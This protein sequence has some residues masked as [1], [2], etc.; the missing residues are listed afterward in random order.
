MTEV[1]SLRH[2]YLFNTTVA[3]SNKRPGPS[4]FTLF[5]K[6]PTEL[7]QI[8]WHSSLERSRIIFLNIVNTDPSLVGNEPYDVVSEQETRLL[9][10]LLRVNRDARMAALIFYRVHLPCKAWVGCSRTEAMTLHINPEYDILYLVTSAGASLLPFIHFLKTLDP[11]QVGLLNLALRH[12]ELVALKREKPDEYESGLKKSLTDMLGKLKQVYLMQLNKTGR[13]LPIVQGRYD[14][15]TIQ[16]NRSYPLM[17]NNTSFQRFKRDPR[18]IGLDLKA[19]YLD[20]N[21][22]AMMGIWKE[23]MENWGVETSQTEIR[24]LVSSYEWYECGSGVAIQAVLDGEEDS[25]CVEAKAE[26]HTSSS[27]FWS[28]NEA[29]PTDEQVQEAAAVLPAIGFWLF[30]PEAV[31]SYR[32]HNWRGGW[33]LIDVS[34]YWPELCVFDV[35]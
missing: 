32:E 18:A 14:P 10:K 20:Y 31:P 30:P 6:L 28:K 21:T 7:R 25:V 17:V 4:E 2:D 5:P 19:V 3:A 1:S 15:N 29:K 34:R 26:W 13:A 35:D 16:T 11:K 27:R 23:A 8:I 24:H 12:G 9:S 33:N 22:P